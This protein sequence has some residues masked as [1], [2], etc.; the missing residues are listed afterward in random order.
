MVKEKVIELKRDFSQV[1]K[2]IKYVLFFLSL[3]ATLVIY[4]Q[5]YFQ[6]EREIMTLSKIKNQIQA[7][8]L[9]LKK[10]ISR[11][12]SPDRIENIATGRLKMKPVSYSK[13]RF[14]DNK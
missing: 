10:E 6:V 11:L 1:G 8:N 2:Y 13:V 4:N 5:Y 7:Q 14:I 3:A 12:S 9:T